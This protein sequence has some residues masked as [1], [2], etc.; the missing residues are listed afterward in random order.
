DAICLP[1]TRV[2]ILERIDTWIR[3]RKSSENVLWMRG[4]AG[5]GKSAIAST[6]AYR[7]RFNAATA[8][9]HFRRG[10]KA[11]DTGLVCALARQL[12]GNDLVPELKKPILEA[13]AND[14]DIGQK[15]LQDQFQKLFAAPLAKL[16][17]ESAPVLLIIDALDECEDVKYAVE[18]VKLIDRYASSFPATVKFLLTTRPETPLLRALEPIQGQT[19]NLD[20]A[21]NV[22]DDVAQFFQAGFSKIRKQHNLGENWPNP[23]NIQALVDM[24]QGLFQWA[25]TAIEYIMEGSPQLRIQELLLSPSICDG[26]DALYQQILLEAFKKVSKSPLRRDIFLQVLGVLV[27]APYTISLEVLASLFA[28]HT[29]FQK[30][31]DIVGLLRAEALNDLKSLVHVPDLSTDPVHLMHTSVR[32]LLVNSERCGGA[33]Y[34]VDLAIN[35]RSLALK[36]LELMVCDLTTNICK[37]SDLSKPNSDHSIQELVSLHVCQGLQ[38]SC[39]SWAFHLKAGWTEVA[40]DWQEVLL[41]VKVF[42]EKKLLGWLEVMSLIGETRQSLAIAKQFNLWAQLTD[43]ADPMVTTLWD[44]V[45]RFIHA[46]Y[47]PIDFGALH[48]YASA[49]PV[50]PINSS[51]WHKYSA[52]EMTHV[53]N[54]PRGLGWPSS[55]WSKHT[56]AEVCA[57]TFAQD[58]GMIAFGLDDGTCQ[59]WDMETGVPIG[60]PLRGHDSLVR[61]VAF[62]PDGK[63]LASG[64]ADQTIRLW[65]A[66]TGAPIG[67]P[68]RGHEGWGWVQSVAFS[69]DSNLLA[70]GSADKTIQLWDAK[71]GA[72]IGEPLRG[73]DSS[74]PSVAFFP[75]G[76]LLASGSNDKTIRLW[77]AKTRAP[78]GEPLR[79]HEGWVQSVAFSPD[80]NFL[81]S[82]SA[83]KTIRL[84]DAK[85]GTPIGEPLRGHDNEINSVAFSPDGK[86]L[87]SESDDQTI[88]LWDAKTGALI[89][90]SLSHHDDQ[91]NKP[92]RGHDGLVLSV[93]F[94]LDGKLLASGSNDQTIRLWD[95]KTGAPIGEPLRGHGDLVR[96]VAFSPDGKLLASRSFDQTIRLWDAKTGGPIQKP[97]GDYED[98]INIPGLCTNSSLFFY[99]H[100][101]PPSAITAPSDNL[102]FSANHLHKHLLPLSPQIRLSFQGQWTVSSGF[103]LNPG[104]TPPVR[105][106]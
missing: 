75:D 39:R 25:H 84:W 93:A 41:H 11:S 88:R 44:D 40:S 91:I 46:F 89:Q 87:T 64:S 68:L 23:E 94:S 14:E 54:G 95:A 100:H 98:N 101:S 37:L 35:H 76:K 83:D 34:A 30:Q 50:C 104:S 74:V 72:P 12:G 20:S 77:D 62:S 28:D 102:A 47:E 105:L 79:G 99:Q 92:L 38:Y 15:R 73:H 51:L 103:P 90:K 4:M 65:D 6:V 67:E 43:M 56:N 80:S 33:P 49:L 36:C 26:L 71:T 16:P 21:T 45:Q 63:L 8:I 5:R 55:L 48:I 61:S 42:S 78:I 7:W 70:S 1:N 3:S 24:S 9:F 17:S 32:D 57:I 69:P 13:V 19:E 106:P 59:F 66:K 85:T 52:Y 97:L 96:S 86:L 22:G 27:V 81:A 29:L 53:V 18:F 10:Q 2:Q 58:E 60:E 31:S 82:G